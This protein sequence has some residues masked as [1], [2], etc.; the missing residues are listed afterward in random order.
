MGNV[1][2]SIMASTLNV[3]KDILMDNIVHIAGIALSIVTLQY[4]YFLAKRFVIQSWNE[5]KKMAR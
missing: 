3:F 2:A 1:T 5:G 4:L